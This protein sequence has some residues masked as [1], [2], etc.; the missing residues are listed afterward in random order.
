MVSRVFSDRGRVSA[1]AIAK[2]RAASKELGY[3]PNALARS[4]IT[5]RSNIIGLVMGDLR[6]PFYSEAIE[7]LSPALQ[8]AGRQLMIFTSPQNASGIDDV[9]ASIMDYKVDGMIMVSAAL[10]DTLA[11]RCIAEGIPVVFFGRT[12]FDESFSS[13]TTDGFEGARLAV[14]HLLETGRRRLAHITGDPETR[15]AVERRAGFEA[16]L[17]AAGLEPAGIAEGSYS[18]DVGAMATRALFCGPDCPDGVFV[19]NDFMAFAA[20]DTLRFEIGLRV[21]EDVGV[22]GFDGLRCAG[23]PAYDLTT[24]RQDIATMVAE[25]VALLVDGATTGRTEGRSVLLPPTLVTRGS[26]QSGRSSG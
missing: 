8:E 21:P 5:G 22:V 11:E 6:N 17:A 19:A 20:I 4:L 1:T 13:V 2:V 14:R 24:V 7:L 18:A 26:S 23:A 16:E 3:R 10:P 12:S 9:I 15:S 25:T